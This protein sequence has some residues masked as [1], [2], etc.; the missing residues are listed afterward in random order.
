MSQQVII[1]GSHDSTF[2]QTPLLWKWGKLWVIESPW[3]LARFIAFSAGGHG[4][5][6]PQQSSA[7]R[8]AVLSSHHL[9][10]IWAPR[11]ANVIQI[12]RLFARTICRYLVGPFE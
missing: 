4:Y 7:R 6:R 3:P 5:T 1:K 8:V 9:R 2:D 11:T 10:Q 12:L